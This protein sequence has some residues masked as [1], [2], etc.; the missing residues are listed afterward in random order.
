MYV[1]VESSQNDI[2]SVGFADEVIQAV[3]Y[4]VR[5]QI[6]FKYTPNYVYLKDNAVVSIG[7]EKIDLSSLKQGLGISG[8]DIG[9][10]RFC[11]TAGIRKVITIE[12]LTTYFR[13]QEDDALLFRLTNIRWAQENDENAKFCLMRYDGGG[14]AVDE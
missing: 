3:N 9:R 4:I 14:K 2:T 6:C 12:N 1:L 5:R 11:N 7:K 10:I 8:E 13:W